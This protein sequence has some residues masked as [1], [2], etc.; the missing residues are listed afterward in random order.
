MESILELRG[1]VKLFPNQR[2][3]DGISL[4]IPRA[5]SYSLLDVSP[6]Q[7]ALNNR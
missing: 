3:V 6:K 5:G 4:K 2:A 1:L 7:G